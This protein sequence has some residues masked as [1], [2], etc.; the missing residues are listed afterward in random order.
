MPRKGRRSEAAR[1]RWSRL[2]QEEPRPS[3]PPPQAVQTVSPQVEE[4]RK[5]PIPSRRSRTMDTPTPGSR[6]PVS[7][8][9]GWSLPARLLWGPDDARATLAARR[10]T[11]YRHSARTWPTSPFT[12]RQHKL[13]VPPE[14]PDKK[15]VLIVGDSHLRALVDGLVDMPEGCL[16]FGFMSTPGASASQ[17]RT[18]VQHAVLPRIPEA[19][20]LLA[21][22]NNLTASRTVDEAA[23]DFAKLLTTVRNRWPK[24]FVVD[25][26]PRLN[27]EVSYQDFLRQE[28]HR[29]AARMGVKYSSVAEH[30]PLTRL[31]LWSRKD[32]VHLSDH[33][34]MGILTQ[35]LWSAAMHQ[36]ET[37]PPAPQVSPRPSQPLR[38]FSPKLVVVGD[39][40]APR[41]PDP[42]QW[43]TARQGSKVSQP[44]KPSQSQQ[45]EKECSF[46]L[47]PVWFSSATL[48]AMEEVSP[49]T[50]SRPVDCQP[51]PKP[52]RVASS[53][54]AKRPRTPRSN[55]SSVNNV[56]GWITP[57]Q[58]VLE[59]RRC[60]N[61]L[62]A[63][64]CKGGFRNASPVPGPPPRTNRSSVNN[65]SGWIT[66]SQ[67]VLEIR[68][69]GNPLLATGCKGGFR[70]ASQAPPNPPQQPVFSEQPGW[71]TPSQVVLEI[72]W[73]R[74]LHQPDRL[75]PLW[76]Q[77]ATLHPRLR[78]PRL[79]HQPGRLGPLGMQPATLL[80]CLRQLAHE[81]QQCPYHLSFPS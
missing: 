69:R 66:P 73:P 40:L 35:L 52:K 59:I 43:R 54:P 20:C 22:S 53:A 1:L 5:E 32:G 57:S 70:N 76:M 79:L 36:L 78:W 14:S 60:G 58:V 17:L 13:V 33:E 2:N 62:L 68:R 10:G 63:T 4:S 65:V 51:S 42:F 48:R 46:P 19:V 44:G 31:E 80:P 64:G 29:V 27:V 45:Q 34:G 61:P 77:P 38:K 11:G 55:G 8:L 47:N 16:S 41:S 9:V 23:I 30:F 28:F 18:E 72:R 74:L 21:P 67:V 25:F 15:F 71:I 56:S 81:L 24:V 7:N 37:P 12:G 39:V 49:S 50:F 3:S 6:S 75:G 26:P